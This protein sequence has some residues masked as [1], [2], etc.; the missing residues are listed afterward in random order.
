M[1]ERIIE[2]HPFAPFLPEGAVMLMLGSAPPPQA[3]WSMPFYYPNL[4]ND[5]WRIF[6]LVFFADRDHFMEPDGKRFS[7]PAIELFLRQRG[8]AL[9]DTG[10]SYVRHRGNA[11][12]KFLEIV[13]TVDLAALVGHLPRC[14][15]IVTTGE[16]ATEALLSITGAEAPAVGGY[17]EFEFGGRQMRHYRMPSSSRAYPRPLAEKAEVYAQMFRNEGMMG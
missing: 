14:R 8:I 6:G 11:S 5:M 2:Q 12:D 17:S 16:K 10:S 4:Q 15:A 7:Q 1:D 9:S 13:A 3:R